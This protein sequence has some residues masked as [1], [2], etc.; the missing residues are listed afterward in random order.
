MHTDDLLGKRVVQI[1]TRKENTKKGREYIATIKFEDG[2]TIVFRPHMNENGKFV[3]LFT[4]VG[5]ESQPKS[6]G[7]KLLDKAVLSLKM[8]IEKYEEKNIPKAEEPVDEFSE[9]IE[10]PNAKEDAQRTEE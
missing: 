8:K 7:Q 4:I 9:T 2:S 10:I 1:K 3:S 6:W 5:R